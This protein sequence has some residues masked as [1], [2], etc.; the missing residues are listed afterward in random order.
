MLFINNILTDNIF[1]LL[2]YAYVIKL[3]RIFIYY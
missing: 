2:N 3:I 1:I